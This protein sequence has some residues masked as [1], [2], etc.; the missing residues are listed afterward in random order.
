MEFGV[1]EGAGGGKVSRDGQ[2]RNTEQ[3]AKL[4]QSLSQ[5]FGRKVVDK[6][7]R[8]QHGIGQPG[9]VGTR[10]VGYSPHSDDRRIRRVDLW[11]TPCGK[12]G[13]SKKRLFKGQDVLNR[14]R[15]F[16]ES[17]RYMAPKILNKEGDR[18]TR[19]RVKQKRPMSFCDV[20]WEEREAEKQRQRSEVGT[21][22]GDEL[23]QPQREKDGLQRQDEKRAQAPAGEKMGVLGVEFPGIVEREVERQTTHQSLELDDNVEVIDLRDDSSTSDN[24][25]DLISDND[26][27]ED[28]EKEQQQQEEEAIEEEE[29]SIM[30]EKNIKANW[31]SKNACFSNRKGPREVNSSSFIGRRA[32]RGNVPSTRSAWLNAA[33]AWRQKNMPT[34]SELRERKT[35]ASRRAS[36]AAKIRSRNG[37]RFQEGMPEP[38]HVVHPIRVPSKPDVDASEAEWR[39]Y[40]KNLHAARIASA[41]SFV[42]VLRAFDVSCKDPE[43]I[44]GAYMQA[45]RMYHPD[46]NSKL[47][48]WSTDREKAEAEE[49]MKLI[50]QRKPHEF[51]I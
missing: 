42:Q 20:L 22:Q 32:V 33:M 2:G 36:E 5:R 9:A 51:S 8:E 35:E 13:H 45:V 23:V 43:N 3:G 44:K 7:R 39:L 27:V 41:S 49:I 1:A 47:R 48:T 37:T 28:N 18:K 10:K 34:E 16:R 46:S 31:K 15:C 26:N 40:F 30:S 17:S 38:E 25:E 11:S 29:G 4:F 12:Q 19:L 24:S 21:G 50:N 14:D 6:G